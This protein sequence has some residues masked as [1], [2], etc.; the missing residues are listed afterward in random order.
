MDSFDFVVLGG[1]SAGVEAAE[2][3]AGAGRRVALV[4][5]ARVGGVCPFTACMPSKAMLR[6]AAV[7]H[8]VGR[9]GALGATALPPALDEP[10]RAYP[11]AVG[12]R[13]EITAGGDDAGEAAPLEKQG[14]TILRGRGV[15]TRPGVVVVGTS[16]YGYEHLLVATGSS[17]ARPPVDGLDAVPTWTS[18]EALTSPFRPASL[19]ILGGGPVGCELAQIYARFGVEVAV[20]EPSDRLADR[21]EPEISECLAGVLRADGVSLRLGVEVEAAEAAGAG[22]RLRLSDGSTVEAQR[23]LVATGRTPNVAGVGL[24]ALGVEPGERGIEV[25]PDCRV[26]GQERVWAAGDVTG[27]APFTH[28]A[29]YQARVVA[30]NVLGGDARADYSALP[31]SIFT[32]PAVA[33]VGA[34][35]AG[36]R[37]EGLEAVASTARLGETARALSEGD[38]EGLLV[39]VAD[40]RRQVLVGASAIGPHAD[41]WLGEAVLAVRAAVPL[42]LL[43]DVVHA[44][45]TFGEAFEPAL[46]DLPRAMIG[47]VTRSRWCRGGRGAG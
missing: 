18:D 23:V 31:R 42:P 43:V 11:M 5:E 4:E 10:G 24:A 26:A 7:R 8:L 29:K 30:E 36:A 33:S 32:D 40:R 45:P 14:V 22:A 9:A 13:E 20:V 39:L 44:F 47:P 12:R 21:E 41:E 37:Q 38:G 28:V 3:V 6:S 34:T 27:V 1:G 2:R 16:E 17:P 15:I 25:G 46:R 35:L 19:A